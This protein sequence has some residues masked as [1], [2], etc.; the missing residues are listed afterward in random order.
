MVSK[1]G[2]LA[3][4]LMTST[5]AAAGPAIPPAPLPAPTGTIVNVSTVAQLQSAVAS[6][7]SNRTIV[8][9]PGTYNLTATLY[10]NG[11]F[12]NVG[13]RGATGNRSTW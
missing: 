2:W 12:T 7:A 13:I 6:M 11:A 4:L 5:A 1:A 8:I 10:I 9:A 3:L